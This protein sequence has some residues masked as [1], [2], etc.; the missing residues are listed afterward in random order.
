VNDDQIL[1][2]LR[3]RGRA[4]PPMDLVGSVLA[5]I[6]ESPPRRASWIAPFMPI[7]AALGAAA[8]IAV[9]IL[10]SQD[11]DISTPNPSGGPSSSAA[12]SP[13][14]SPRPAPSLPGSIGDRLL[15]VG[16]VVVMP[17]F[18]DLGEWGTIRLERGDELRPSD[19]AWSTYE[20]GSVLIEIHVTYTAERDTSQLF[21]DS[22]WG[23]RIQ[24]EIPGVAGSDVLPGRTDPDRPVGDSLAGQGSASEGSV[25][26]GWIALE[27]PIVEDTPGVFV[28]YKGGQR[29][30]GS[31]ST[32]LWEV[33]VRERERNA[34]PRVGADLLEVG[35]ATL[36]PARTPDGPFGMITLDRGRD[37]GGYPLVLDPSSST[38]FFIEVR[39]TYEVGDIPEGAQFGDIDWRV[40]GEDG[41][42]EGELLHASPLVRGRGEIGSW[43]SVAL[44]PETLYEGWIILAIPREDA[45]TNLELVYQP[46]GVTDATRIPVRAP[47]EAPT[48]VAAEWPYTEP[49]YVARAGLPF[50]VI[51]SA[52]AD[53]LF[54]DADTCTNPE[55]GYTV[56]YPDSWY[57]NTDL[58]NV[59]A[60]SWFSPTF[61]ELNESGDRPEE[62]A[63]EI[64]VF[65]GAVGFIWVDLYSEQI[66]LDGFDARRAETGMTKGPE[67]PTDTYQYDY[68][69]YLDTDTDGGKLWAFTGT[70]YGGDY[71]LNMAVMDRI[72]ASL[73]FTD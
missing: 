18:D 21:G 46:P 41:T 38:H 2:Y 6:A 67:M 45:Q 55:G 52:E 39:A 49:T 9:V 33:L 17:A 70:E 53:A 5:A 62:I 66:T 72:M 23:V 58:D 12:P 34:P 42:V 30:E 56:S 28:T 36:L 71:E 11:R 57:T 4:E 43:P 35:D 25:T 69:A 60:C 27:V 29:P 3:A 54:V 1:E 64:R 13:S 15:E 59:P 73:E 37:V 22:D 63:L 16:D 68:L 48:P 50:T 31:T 14:A 44:V 61:Y 7:G 51:E 47:G 24:D 8:I 20:G 10:L 65:D 26:E 32:P 40:E 19:S